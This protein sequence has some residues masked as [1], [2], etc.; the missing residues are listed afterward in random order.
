MDQ[1]GG[2]ELGGVEDRRTTAVFVDILPCVLPDVVLCGEEPPVFVVGVP[3]PGH[4]IADRN[5]READ[6]VGLGVLEEVHE[7][8]EP[9]VAPTYEP[10]PPGVQETVT[11]QEGLPGG[12]NILHLKPS[13]VHLPVETRSVPCA[14]P[15]LRSGHRITLG[16]KF[17]NNVGVV[18]REVGVDPAVRK[19]EKGE[20]LP[21]LHPLGKEEVGP[22]LDGV[23]GPH[24]GW[25]IDSG[26]RR[27]RDEELVHPGHVGESLEPEDV[28]DRFFQLV[29]AV[30]KGI[31]PLLVRFL[32]R[33]S[34]LGAEERSP[35]QERHCQDRHDL[36]EI[37]HGF[38]PEASASSKTILRD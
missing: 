28:V 13:V 22:K 20:L 33:S 19:D 3:H 35:H 36:Q 7:G 9:A 18:G 25:F 1:E 23:L 38:L 29:E 26:R 2:L 16:D 32:L 10:D 37:L 8:D 14:S 21:S 12:V 34:A 17:P 4:Q 6:R 27:A 24:E 31:P 30:V 15:V 5:S 11:L